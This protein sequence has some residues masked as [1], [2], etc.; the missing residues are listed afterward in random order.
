MKT[1]KDF[2]FRS[3]APEGT[4]HPEEEITLTIQEVNEMRAT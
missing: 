1:R 2:V 4:Q 3:G